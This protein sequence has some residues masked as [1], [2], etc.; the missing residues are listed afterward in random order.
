MSRTE[1]HW[2]TK[3]GSKKGVYTPLEIMNTICDSRVFGFCGDN[4]IVSFLDLERAQRYFDTEEKVAIHGLD[5][6]LSVEKKA[7]LP[8]EGESKDGYYRTVM[9]SG[10]EKDYIVLMKMFTVGQI[11]TFI[12][13]NANQF[14]A[15]YL[16]GYLSALRENISDW[17]ILQL[18]KGTGLKDSELFCHAANMESIDELVGI[19]SENSYTVVEVAPH[20]FYR[21][22]LEDQSFSYLNTED[23]LKIMTENIIN[24]ARKYK[25]CILS[26]TSLPCYINKSGQQ[27]YEVLKS[28]DTHNYIGGKFFTT[29]EMKE[30]F[31]YMD[32]SIVN[33]MLFL[34]EDSIIHNLYADLPTRT[35]LA[36]N[37]EKYESDD[38]IKNY[39]ILSEKCF[40]KLFEIYGET[41]DE[42]YIS[43]LEGELNAI[44]KTKSASKIWYVYSLINNLNFT[45]SDIIP[46]GYTGNLF[47]TYLLGI[48]EF[49]PIDYDIPECFMIDC[50]KNTIRDFSISIANNDFDEIYSNL[51]EI[52]G[53]FSVVLLSDRENIG[54]Q[55]VLGDTFYKDEERFVFC[56][57]GEVIFDKIPLTVSDDGYLISYYSDNELCDMGDIDLLEIQSCEGLRLLKEMSLLSGQRVPEEAVIDNEII[58]ILKLDGK[59]IKEVL[60][61]NYIYGFDN[62]KFVELATKYPINSFEDAVKV[63][64][65]SKSKG[66]FYKKAN[67][68]Q[69]ELTFNE[70]IT[71][72]EDL[73]SYMKYEGV[74]A[75]VAY[76]YA[77]VISEGEHKADPIKFAEKDIP[78]LLKYGLSEH[79]IRYTINRIEYLPQKA[80]CLKYTHIAFE[81]LW[82]MIY[83]NS[84][85][86]EVIFKD[87]PFR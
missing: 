71:T 77:E 80:E 66:D 53:E 69:R 5:V 7:I 46:L 25:C 37:Y 47:V 85:F 14:E 20:Y 27:A 13:K 32:G 79:F 40:E 50:D 3:N 17:D 31:D 9:Y 81:M 33:D 62:N 86:E 18:S 38:E 58:N 45:A 35:N 68:N 12:E 65:L 21:D 49:N 51:S 23:D 48:S 63:F 73:Y 44:Q 55:D 39:E 42:M 6:L 61:D 67:K 11:E 43:R 78:E 30:A 56:N 10:T 28:E 60:F 34:N 19:L 57:R 76:M 87:K 59:Q 1:L 22:L 75:K 54:L 26:A 2:Y 72:R 36:K 41:P 16:I 24:A 82:Y 70:L 83:F 64:A 29:K 15:S 4:D 74:P 52:I 84:V 8:Y